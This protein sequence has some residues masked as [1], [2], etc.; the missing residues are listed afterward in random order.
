MGR[1]KGNMRI[2]SPVHRTW[3]IKCAPDRERDLLIAVWIQHREHSREC[4]VRVGILGITWRAETSVLSETLAS[5]TGS[6]MTTEGFPV[7][8][9]HCVS[10]RDRT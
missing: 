3:G 6:G 5:V 9:S 4:R 8:D 2:L 10:Q 1:I 7:V